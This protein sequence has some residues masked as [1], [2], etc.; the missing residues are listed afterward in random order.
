LWLALLSAGCPNSSERPIKTEAD[1]SAPVEVRRLDR[2]PRFTMVAREGDPRA[3][4]VVAIAADAGPAGHTAL[5]SLLEE[6][7]ARAGFRVSTRSDG[8]GLRIELA[9]VEIA[10]LEAFMN[11]L[12]EAVETPIGAREPGLKL[13]RMRLEALRQKPLDGPALVP[14]ARCSGDLAVLAS[15]PALDLSTRQGIAKLESWRARGLVAERASIAVVGPT[16]IG[17][18][19]FTALERSQPWTQGAAPPQKVLK[20]SHAAYSSSELGEGEVRL[21]V[22]V[23]LPR[24]DQAAAA[25][26]R[27]SQPQSA[28]QLK[29]AALPHD[30]QLVE[31]RATA[32]LD[33]GCVRLRL[34]PRQAPLR[35]VLPDAAARALALVRHELALQADLDGGSFAVAR[36]IVGAADAREAAARAAWWALSGRASRTTSV[37]TALAVSAQGKETPVTGDLDAR[38]RRAAG[39]LSAPRAS[40]IVAQRQSIERGQGEVWVLIGS[41]CAMMDEGPWDAGRAA[42]AAVSVAAAAPPRADVTVAPWVTG[43]GVGIL[44][45]GGAFF[46]GEPAEAVARRVARAAA[47]TFTSLPEEGALA[48]AKQTIVDLLGPTRGYAAIARATVPNHPSWIAPWG[49]P[50]EHAGATAIDLRDRWRGVLRSP[51]RAAV[52][53]NAGKAQAAEAFAELDRWLLVEARGRPCSTVAAAPE[54]PS[55]GLHPLAAGSSSEAYG[56][57]FVATAVPADRVYAELAAAALDSVIAKSLAAGD[58]GSVYVAGGGRARALVIHV[59]T[60]PA[61]LP[62]VRERLVG[63]LGTVAREGLSDPARRAAASR[64]RERF[65]NL[66]SHP[67]ERLDALWRDDR[68]GADAYARV[69]GAGLNRWLARA[70]A[71]AQLVILTDEP[72]SP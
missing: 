28:L 66:R 42:L 69:D 38:Y 26:Q 67:R 57:L 49:D 72:E 31:L 44:A 27:M 6:R 8:L 7:L 4:L 41:P 5:A 13:A 56:E 14:L 52:I 30:W 53:A 35:S 29:L 70:L 24:A 17:D 21:D 3:A 20:D 10:R 58:R 55:A 2:K 22:A 68:A 32:R 63:A 23:Q 62:G 16:E 19:A 47:Q 65:E 64:A 12:G 50:E 39:A 34:R 25:A 40:P 15:A 33:G 60:S 59:E 71:P 43:D 54:A 11:A 37:H 51:I 9:P 48:R 18:A 45:H 1:G 61:S 36:S 46:P